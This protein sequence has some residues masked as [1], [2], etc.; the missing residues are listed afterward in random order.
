MIV[1]CHVYPTLHL[2]YYLYYLPTFPDHR[3]VSEQ[4]A[5]NWRLRFFTIIPAYG[6]VAI[7]AI[8]SIWRIGRSRFFSL[9]QHRLFFTWF[10]VAFLLANHE[11]FMPAKQPL[12]FTRG[13]IWT[14]LFLLGIPGLHYLLDRLRKVRFGYVAIGAFFPTALFR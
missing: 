1:Y 5:L 11:I 3:S 14:S 7:L 9:P 13:Y 8:A 10:I 2:F 4:Y 6:P 12:H